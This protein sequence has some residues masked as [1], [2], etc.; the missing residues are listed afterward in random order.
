MNETSTVQP[1][2][3]A[4]A[5]LARAG[6]TLNHEATQ[7]AQALVA[8]GVGVNPS[9]LRGLVNALGAGPARRQP[10][11]RHRELARYVAWRATRAKPHTG[12]DRLAEPIKEQILAL[13]GRCQEMTA[14][15]RTAD[16][17][18]WATYPMALQEEQVQLE[19][20]VLETFV[21]ALAREAADKSP[22]EA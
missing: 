19:L 10:A 18:Y 3:R 14:E 20:R 17:G 16:A 7:A 22:R 6:L 4:R 12:W 1:T 8:A 21:H 2:Q 11:E 5:L 15:V 9:Q 13:E